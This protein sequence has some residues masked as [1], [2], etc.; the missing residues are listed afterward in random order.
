MNATALFH[1]AQK[2]PG[3]FHYRD[4]LIYSTAYASLFIDL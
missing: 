1:H 2:N 4:S 3:S